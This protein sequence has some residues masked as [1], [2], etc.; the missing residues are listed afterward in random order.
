MVVGDVLNVW[1]CGVSGH[2][3]VVHFT[4]SIIYCVGS[5]TMA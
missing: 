2:V 3:Q 5:L 4:V 1:R